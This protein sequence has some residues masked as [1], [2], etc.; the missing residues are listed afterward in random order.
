MEIDVKKTY[1]TMN[2]GVLRRSILA[3]GAAGLVASVGRPVE[4]LAQDDEIVVADWGGDSDTFLKTSWTDIL[5][6]NGIKLA[7]DTSGPAPG[8]IRAMVDSGKVI[9]D[10]CDTSAGGTF[11][12]GGSGMLN[13][14]DYSIVDK[15]KVRPEFAFKYSVCN[16]MY[17]YVMAVNAAKFEGKPVPKTWAD[18]YDLKKFPG[19]RMLRALFEG[20]LE[21]ALLADGVAPKDLYPLDVDRALAKI[22]TIKAQTIFWN[23]GAESENLMRQGEVVMGNMWNARAYTLYKESGGKTAW[24]WEG[25]VLAPAVWA[26]PKGN[27]AGKQAAMRCIAAMQDPAGQADYFK[28]NGSYP[29]NPAAVALVP[30]DLKPFDGSQPENVDWYAKN[31]AEAQA[32]YLQ[33]RSS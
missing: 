3:G 15:G 26:V 16:Y 33:M 32:K 29:A 6:R 10:V 31:S 22:N 25:A 1:Q 14:I 8:K 21:G 20:Q 2:A 19:R 13:E 18:F 30:A 24:S 27:P 23:T 28:R 4:A 17:S 11:Q 7:T 9:W 12:L 5:A